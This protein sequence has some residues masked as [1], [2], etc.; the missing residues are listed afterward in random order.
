MIGGRG[1]YY[2]G[3]SHSCGIQ[4]FVPIRSCLVY[5]VKW[6]LKYDYKWYDVHFVGLN[7]I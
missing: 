4:G 2:L 6:I 3:L 5:N 7:E 1:L